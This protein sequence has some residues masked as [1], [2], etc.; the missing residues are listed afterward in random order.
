VRPSKVL[1]G[2]TL[3]GFGAYFLLEPP[4]ERFWKLV[5]ALEA[6]W[7]YLALGLAAA[8][9]VR[10]LLSEGRWI[11]PGVLSAVG[12]AAL[13]ARSPVEVATFAEHVL[14][15]ALLLAG[16]FVVAGGGSHSTSR[17][18][19]AALFTRTFIPEGE[20]RSP[21]VAVACLAELRLDLT[22]LVWEPDCVVAASVFFGRIRISLPQDL[23]LDLADGGF[24]VQ[25]VESG[26]RRYHNSPLALVEVRGLLGRIDVVRA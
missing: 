10:T 22:Q 11:A 2:T 15:P 5:H 21:L 7:P 8:N 23:S 25:V 1:L 17:K 12:G 24:M 4:T 18:W 3:V 9:L 20:A 6:T 13:L 19:V 26:T 16:I 14:V